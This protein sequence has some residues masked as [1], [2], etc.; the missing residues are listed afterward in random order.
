M[1]EPL[2]LHRGVY[3]TRGAA[4]NRI[5]SWLRRDL[6]TLVSDDRART[7]L[8]ISAQCALLGPEWDDPDTLAAVLTLDAG[9]HDRIDVAFETRSGTATTSA[10]P[11]KNDHVEWVGP[12]LFEDGFAR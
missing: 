2:V 1:N 3:D 8:S 9:S 10:W 6:A 7:R 5:N 12:N 11:A 4:A